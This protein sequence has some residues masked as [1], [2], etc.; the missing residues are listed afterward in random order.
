M[1]NFRAMVEKASWDPETITEEEKTEYKPVVV[2]TCYGGFNLSDEAYNF[3]GKDW[4]GDRDELKLVECIRKLGR[5]ASGNY[6][7]LEIEYIPSC[8]DYTI[9]EYDGIEYI[10]LL[11]K[12]AVIK[13]L[14][15]DV[16][17]IIAYL[18]AIDSFVYNKIK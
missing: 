13:D 2:N 15:N 12:K 1:K 4:H 7:R 18:E 16:D 3:L 9:E 6:S 11:P 17:S 5:Q 10:R 14:A 8:Y